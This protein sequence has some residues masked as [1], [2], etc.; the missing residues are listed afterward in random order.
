MTGA[1]TDFERARVSA[2][3][4]RVP[5]LSLARRVF[6]GLLAAAASAGVLVGDGWRTGTVW[7]PFIDLGASVLASRVAVV[8]PTSVLAIVGLAMH[9]LLLAL[10]GYC[11]TAVARSLRGG[12]LF[13][14]AL[15]I[16]VV[17]WIVTRVALPRALGA[18]E[19]SLMSPAH[20]L[21]YLA[22]IAIALS[23]GTRLARYA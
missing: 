14:A 7:T 22:T 16:T 10:W 18:A 5:R 4:S 23:L 3:S 15:M 8:L 19:W 13:I 2:Q 11:F 9:T 6:P 21:L 12:K 17:L 20:V 1:S